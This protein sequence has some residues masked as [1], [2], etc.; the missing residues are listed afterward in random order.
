MQPAM[1]LKIHLSDPGYNGTGPSYLWA[2]T[3]PGTYS[4]GGAAWCYMGG[5]TTNLQVYCEAFYPEADADFRTYVTPGP[6]T[7]APNTL[8]LF[9]FQFFS[10]QQGQTL[11][12]SNAISFNFTS[13]DSGATFECS[14]DD[15][16]WESCVS[17]KWFYGLSNGSHTV[18]VRA[19]D[20]AGNYDQTP[21][22]FQFYV[23]YD[24]PETFIDSKPSNPSNDD[25]P[26]FAFSSDSNY[27]FY[28]C[29][30]SHGGTT[31][32]WRGCNS[33]YT[34]DRLAEGGEYTFEVRS[35]KSTDHGWVQ[36]PSPASYTWTYTGVPAPSAPVIT[37]PAN[38][39][40]DKDGIFTVS[41]TAE[42]G[43]MIELF[44]GTTSKGTTEATGG[45]WSIPLSGISEGSHTYAA[46]AKDSTGN[47]SDESNALTVIVDGTA[48][49]APAINSPANN[50]FDTDGNVTLAGTAEEGSTVEVFDGPTSKG[51]TAVDSSGAWSKTLSAVGEGS[52]T[53]TAKA[54]DAA[55]NTSGSGGPIT[56]KV[57]TTKPTVIGMTP[58][59]RATGV[60]LGTNLTATFSEKMKASSIVTP[61]TTFKLFKV[62]PD[63]TQTRI[64][65]VVVS[66]SSDGLTAKLNPFGTTTT[67]LARNTKYKGV[68]TTGTKDLADNSL[69]QQKSW[70]FT[71]KP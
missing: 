9:S 22:S 28:D 34:L 19:R 16:A 37:D 62:N 63:G 32:S 23:Q 11:Y 47:V 33:P 58:L 64:T 48:P 54:T 27:A 59:N 14:M 13:D 4:R 31:G 52:H 7:A 66:L 71:T 61:A 55:D 6:D 3:S 12:S 24:P 29:R 21:P 60:G 53:Y 41:G 51:R 49:A 17:P 57:D 67:V 39:S 40:Y 56:V 1:G 68:L 35:Q 45:H 65:D 18:R 38:D 70:T 42:A 20:A 44:E 10:D 5:V 36:D 15:A 43:T 25:T 50:S 69:A 26:T 8:Q 46:K 2:A 30:L